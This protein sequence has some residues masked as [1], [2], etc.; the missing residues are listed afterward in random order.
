[1]GGP[2]P[3]PWERRYRVVSS[4]CWEWTGSLNTSGYGHLRVNGR[5]II[6]SRYAWER[7]HGPIPE[8][9]CVLHTCD[10]RK[11]VNPK[12]LYL[13]THKQN[14]RD[15]S[16]RGRDGGTKRSGDQNIL[17]RHPEKAL[18]GSA[19]A[20]SKLTAQKVVEI[21]QRYFSANGPSQRKLASEYGL[22]QS[23]VGAILRRET[24]AHVP[25]DG[26]FSSGHHYDV[27]PNA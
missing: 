7:A 22:S 17:K 11:C 18:R 9:A 6:A 24:W 25:D 15:R 27:E 23:S 13:G 1:M 3:I 2:K 19:V 20:Q 26:A 8:G 14:A 10:N 12:H 4:G 16:E 21:R 5:L